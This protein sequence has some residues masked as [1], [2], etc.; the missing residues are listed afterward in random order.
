M[1]HLIT[2][3]LLSDLKARLL[4]IWFKTF[5]DN[6]AKKSALMSQ[7]SRASQGATTCP[8]WQGSFQPSLSLCWS[9]VY[10][11]SLQFNPTS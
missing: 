8:A 5:V 7:A 11:D 9:T 10:L 1:E 6:E 2:T 4:F 3:L